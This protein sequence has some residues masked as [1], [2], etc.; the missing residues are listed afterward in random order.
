MSKSILALVCAMMLGAGML[1]ASRLCAA[2]PPPSTQPA[3]PTPV[4][5]KCPVTGEDIDPKFT[6]VYDG[7]VIGFCC[8]DCIKAFKKNPEKYVDKLK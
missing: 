2:D 8:E 5:T 6:T 3:D 4:N 7:K 1:T